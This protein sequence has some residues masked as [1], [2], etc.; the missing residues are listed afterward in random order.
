MT[1]V[2][3]SDGGLPGA[4]PMDYPD[5][6]RLEVPDARPMDYPPDGHLHPFPSDAGRP[7]AGAPPETAGG[8]SSTGAGAGFLGVSLLALLPMA[9]R[10]RP[11]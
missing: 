6:Q 7:D 8:C 5:A 2:D 4:R 3:C 9:L 10:R 1:Y 11:S